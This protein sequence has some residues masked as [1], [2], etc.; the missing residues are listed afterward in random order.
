MQV[1]RILNQFKRT[2]KGLFML[3]SP[4]FNIRN[5][6]PRGK[7]ELFPQNPGCFFSSLA[8]SSDPQCLPVLFTALKAKL[9]NSLLPF[10]HMGSSQI[11]AILSL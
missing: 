7:V 9:L 3:R 10:L 5:K 1:L 4:I 2:Q 8:L 6:F 11:S